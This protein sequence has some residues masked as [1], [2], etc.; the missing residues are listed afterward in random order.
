[1]RSIV[2]FSAVAENTHLT[3]SRMKNEEQRGVH[4]G[5]AFT[6]VAPQRVLM[7]YAGLYIFNSSQGYHLKQKI[8]SLRHLAAQVLKSRWER[9]SITM[10]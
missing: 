10:V 7:P 2:N 9:L 8:R 3:Y 1:M 6:R 4:L 5:V